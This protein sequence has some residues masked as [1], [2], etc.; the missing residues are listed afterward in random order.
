MSKQKNYIHEFF[1]WIDI[2]P[3]RIS[4]VEGVVTYFVSNLP[5][6]FLLFAFF[7]H[8]QDARYEGATVYEALAS[9]IRPGEVF[10]YISTLLAPTVWVMVYHW[11]A[12]RHAVLF[13]FLLGFQ[14]LA[15][16]PAAYMY[17]ADKMNAEINEQFATN[18]A[19]VIYCITL[20]VWYFALVFQKK[21]IDSIGG[22]SEESGSDV[23]RKLR[24]EGRA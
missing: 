14:W 12:R 15:L 17:G 16:L 4:I 22:E 6:L 9:Q 2:S 24:R 7:L 11:R 23:L 20:G 21:K 1:E 13:W 8:T 3:W 19:I 10:V 18:A 5:Y